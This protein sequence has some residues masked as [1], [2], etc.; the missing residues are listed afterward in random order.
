MKYSFSF[1]TRNYECIYTYSFNT[2]AV[3]IQFLYV[4]VEPDGSNCY[5]FVEIYDGKDSKEFDST[6]SKFFYYQFSKF[7]I[8]MYIFQVI[9]QVHL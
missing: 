5:D 3:Q 9:P 2:G 1:S 4:D 8:L 7:D 6:I